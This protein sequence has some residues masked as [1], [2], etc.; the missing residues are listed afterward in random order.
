VLKLLIFD[1]DYGR[2]WL[3]AVQRLASSQHLAL[4]AQINRS[5]RQHKGI[6]DLFVTWPVV[7]VFL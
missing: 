7:T 4:V 5:N 3:A 1:Q 2:D 6:F